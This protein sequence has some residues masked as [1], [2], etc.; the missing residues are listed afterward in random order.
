MIR[1]AQQAPSASAGTSPR[2]RLGLVCP[3]AGAWGLSVPGSYHD[4]WHPVT[5]RRAWRVGVRV[6]ARLI[7]GNSLRWRLSALMFLVY[8]PA[9]AVLPQLPVHLRE[10]GF[11]DA[12]LGAA[13]A[14]QALGS[15]PAPLIA[16]QVAD[17]WVRAD[18]WLTVCAFC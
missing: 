11:T 7:P 1:S 3:R 12:Q 15:L 2:W 16:G 4:C 5:F 14:G 13:C 6:L 18:R 10:I 17:R 8:A 9:G